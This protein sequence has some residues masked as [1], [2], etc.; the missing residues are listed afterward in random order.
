MEVWMLVASDEATISQRV[1]LKMHKYNNSC[2]GTPTAFLGH[3][4]RRTNFTIKQRYEPFLFLLRV[5][6]SRKDFHIPRIGCGAVHS[7]R[8]KVTRPSHNFRHHGVLSSTCPTVN[9]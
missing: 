1:I 6:V 9:H 7:F 3:G 2:V 5:A 4:K 8:R